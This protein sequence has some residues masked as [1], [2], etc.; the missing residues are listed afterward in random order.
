MGNQCKTS[1]LENIKNEE[2]SFKKKCLKIN[3][4]LLNEVEEIKFDIIQQENDKKNPKNV[5]AEVVDLLV[6]KSSIIKEI[7]GEKTDIIYHQNQKNPEKN[8]E[9]QKVEINKELKKWNNKQKKSSK[10][11]SKKKSQNIQN[12]IINNLNENSKEENIVQ[13]EEKKDSKSTFSELLFIPQLSCFKEE[14]KTTIPFI[15]KNNNFKIDVANTLFFRLGANNIYSDEIFIFKYFHPEKSISQWISYE[16][17]TYVVER[18]F[19]F[20][21]E[22]QS[23][24]HSQI[25]ENVLLLGDFVIDGSKWGFVLNLKEC[26]E[27][28]SGKMGTNLI[29]MLSFSFFQSIF[30]KYA[31]Y[32]LDQDEENTYT[33]PTTDEDPLIEPN[34]VPFNDRLFLH[35]KK[36]IGFLHSRE[37]DPYLFLITDLSYIP[38]LDSGYYFKGNNL[39]NMSELVHKK[40]L[41]HSVINVPGG[42]L[43]SD[44]GLGKTISFIALMSIDI[45][46]ESKN[47]QN[48]SLV[49]VTKNILYQWLEEFKKFCPEL[50]V[51][52][53]ENKELFIKEDF[54]KYNPHVVLTYREM[55]DQS[56]PDMLK[57][58]TYSRIVIDEFHEIIHLGKRRK[59]PIKN[60][61]ISNKNECNDVD[62]N[63]NIFMKCLTEIKRKFTWG[64]TGTPNDLDYFNN[65]SGISELL[66]L[67]NEYFQINNYQKIRAK[68]I[69]QCMRRNIKNDQLHPLKKTLR[70]VNFSYVQNLLYQGSQKY[71]MNEEKSRQICNDILDQFDFNK[72]SPENQKEKAIEKIT[73]I[74]NEELTK[75]IQ[76]RELI[77]NNK[78]LIYRIENL[79]SENNFFVKT[80]ELLRNRIYECPICQIDQIQEQNIILSSCF[81]CLC[82]E[83]YDNLKKH[84]I[85]VECPICRNHI[86]DK[87]LLLHP[88]FFKNTESKLD[89]ML[90]E[91]Q[92]IS[93]KEKII[94]FTQYQNLIVK[95]CSMFDKIDIQYVVLKGVPNEINIRLHKFK[96]LPEI[97]IILMSLEQAASGINLQE[98]NNIFFAHPIF[99]FDSEKSIELY[100]QCI[101]RSF[102]IGQTKPVYCKL[103]VTEH[104]IEEKYTEFF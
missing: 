88:R 104:T 22:I 56:F 62:I 91:I 96:T 33:I 64:I 35:Q 17:P 80:I 12:N 19:K 65:V 66:F 100:R 55:I 84:F 102:R 74:M 36:E 41:K 26:E 85:Q 50:R 59:N 20:S 73:T 95:L 47:N 7:E 8:L 63:G 4:N 32:I 11:S 101:G 70:K 9:K 54:I 28:Y 76:Q 40:Q 97:R 5:Q 51:Y 24:F 38:L 30:R 42:I 77:P 23:L 94:I 78:N 27:I 98:A 79:N 10:N 18:K 58:I 39:S 52:L 82:I 86:D 44:V 89:A 25:W 75:L 37:K 99:G 68:F 60:K 21:E 2:N 1:K 72:N 83:C 29:K 93:E 61:K 69:K 87:E 6:Q 48:K 46:L 14:F 16:D 81:H 3:N 90:N 34:L 43:A 13:E 103:F 45:G 57:Y 15:K 31:F 92:K 49:I 71:G 53:Y 67:N